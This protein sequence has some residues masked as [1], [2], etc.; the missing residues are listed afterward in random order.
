ML[1][2][3]DSL[4]EP[5]LPGLRRGLSRLADLGDLLNAMGKLPELAG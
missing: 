5:P 4:G 3:I 1:D 2:A